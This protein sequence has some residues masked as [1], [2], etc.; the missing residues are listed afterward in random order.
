MAVSSLTTAVVELCSFELC[1]LVEDHAKTLE[2]F[3]EMWKQKWPVAWDEVCSRPSPSPSPPHS[4][5]YNQTSLPHI[6]LPLAQPFH[7]FNSLPSTSL[8]SSYSRLPSLSTS[9]S[10]LSPLLLS[11]PS[12]SLSSSHSLL[13]SPPPLTPSYLPLLLSL[14]STPSLSLLPPPS[15]PSYLPF[16][17][18][19]LS[20]PLTSP[21]SL[22]VQI[23]Q[24]LLH[25]PPP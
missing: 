11:L 16:L 6:S 25:A 24:S 2:R 7:P 20:L 14:P 1:R 5:L 8:S 19:S 4:H 22:P 21:I 17:H 15:S 23:Y 10:L 18:L 13:P 9:Y 12:T 3:N